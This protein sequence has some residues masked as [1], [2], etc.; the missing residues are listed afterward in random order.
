M[1][2]AEA[3]PFYATRPDGTS[4]G[5]PAAWTLMTSHGAVRGSSIANDETRP[6]PH[7]GGAQSGLLGAGAADTDMD[8]AVVGGLNS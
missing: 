5:S 3:V 7:P 2:R 8:M 6:T 4:S 1:P